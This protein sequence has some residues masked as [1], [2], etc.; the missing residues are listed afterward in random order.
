[1]SEIPLEIDHISGFLVTSILSHSTDNKSSW[2][3]SQ[4]P[5]L[6]QAIQLSKNKT[7]YSLLPEEILGYS[8]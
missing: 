2:R 1:M 3:T 5:V 4:N 7:D 8:V 6:L